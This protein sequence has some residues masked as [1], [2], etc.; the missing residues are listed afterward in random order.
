MI[1]QQGRQKWLALVSDPRMRRAAEVAGYGL[2]GFCC[3]AVSLAGRS[4]PLAMGLSCALT[5]W[6]ALMAGLGSLLGYLLFWGGDA[7]GMVWSLGGCLIGLLPES[8]GETERP[9][10]LIPALAAFWVSASGLAWQMLLGDTT[11]V[12]FSNVTHRKTNKFFVRTPTFLNV[13]TY[14]HKKV[15][16]VKR[17]TV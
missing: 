3:S 14:I 4:V 1:A 5:G 9:G 16:T 8:P 12:D 17:L 7:V 6:R 2:G 11:P 15:F 10:P 13:V